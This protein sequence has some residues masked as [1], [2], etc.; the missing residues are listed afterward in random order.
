MSLFPLYLNIYLIPIA[1]SA[2][3]RATKT[4]QKMDLHIF[5]SINKSRIYKPNKFI[6]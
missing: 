6:I 3:D 4:T 5:V 2:I 1:I